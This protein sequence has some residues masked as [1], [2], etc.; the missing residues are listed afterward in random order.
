MLVVTCNN[1]LMCTGA[2]SNLNL[3]NTG[4]ITKQKDCYSIS[5]GRNSNAPCD[6]VIQDPEP[7]GG[8]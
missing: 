3:L 4:V 7:Y 5:V 8:S 6:S 1:N 2:V